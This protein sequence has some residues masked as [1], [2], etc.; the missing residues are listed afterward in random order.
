MKTIIPF[1]VFSICFYPSDT[2]A[3]ID[4]LS[5]EGEKWNR[6]LE[7]LL[8]V[9]IHTENDP[10]FLDWAEA[11]CDSLYQLVGYETFA[12]DQRARIDQ[13]RDICGDNLN[14]RAPLLEMFRG[15]PEYMGFA[16]DAVEYALEDA[17][18]KLITRPLIFNSL[19][20]IRNGSLDAIV[21]QGTVPDDLWEIA[22]DILDMETNHNFHRTMT[23][24]QNH[25]DSIIWSAQQNPNNSN[26]KD[27]ADLKEINRFAVIQINI[28]DCVDETLWIVEMNVRIWDE[29]EGFGPV[30][31]AKGF[32]EDKT[33]SPFFW[34]LLNFVLLSFL[35]LT[36]IS[37]IEHTHWGVLRENW[38]NTE[39]TKEK[40][41]F[42]ALFPLSYLKVAVRRMPKTL[43]FLIIPAVTSYIIIQACGPL[44]PGPTTHY[45]EIVAKFWIIGTA[46]GMSLIPTIL[47]FF[48]L[49]R[50]NLDGFHSMKS[51]R[52]LANVSLFG[53]FIPVMYLHEV[54]GTSM[55]ESFVYILILATWMAGDLLAF[56]LTEILSSSKSLRTKRVA[57]IGLLLGVGGV[58]KLTFLVIGSAHLF[59]SIVLTV[60]GGVVNLIWRP[61]MKWAQNKDSLVEQGTNL[62]ADLEEGD[63]VSSLVPN[64]EQIVR[65]IQGPKYT[66]GYIIGPTGIGKT[67]LIKELKKQLASKTEDWRVFIGDCDELQEE[68]HLAFEPFV[69]AFGKLLNIDEVSDRSEIIDAL[70]QS[71]LSAVADVG[72]IAINLKPVEENNQRSLVDFSM[73]LVDHLEKTKGN[74]LFILDDVQW[75][76]DD[77]KKLLLTFW[78][79]VV[80][81]VKLNGRLKFLCTYRAEEDRIS[82]R[83][84]QNDFYDLMRKLEAESILE[85]DGFICR[86]FLK[87]LSDTN[88]EFNVSTNS[89]Y[90]LNNV[91]NKKLESDSS[92][93]IKVVTPLYIIRNIGLLQSNGVLVTGSE[94]WV[95]SRE[96]TVEDLPNSEAVDAH[97]HQIFSKYPAKWMRVLESASIVGR[98]FDATVLSAVWGYELLEVLDFLEQLEAHDILEDVR[99]EDN[100]YRFK[101]K[102]A[103]AGI[104]S[105]FPNNSGDR[106]AR[107]IVIEYTKRLVNTNS[108][109]I[110]KR[111]LHSSGDLWKHLERLLK[112]P[113][114]YDQ[115]IDTY[116]LIEELAIRFAL[117]AEEFGVSPLVKLSSLLRQYFWAS[118]ANQVSTL[119]AVL[120]DDYKEALNRIKILPEWSSGDLRGLNSYT[121]L[122]FDREHVSNL[123]PGQYEMLNSE[124]RR[125]MGLSI[126]EYSQGSLWLGVISLLLSHP[127]VKADGREEIA[128]LWKKRVPLL[129]EQQK[130]SI[131]TFELEIQGKDGA[132]TPEELLD[133]WQN[134][135]TEVV[136]FG[137]LRNQKVVAKAI[138]R[139]FKV[140]TKNYRDAINWFITEES[141]FRVNKSDGITIIWYEVFQE[142]IA[143]AYSRNILCSE[144]TEQLQ[145]WS[146]EIESYFNLR[147]GQ[148]LFSPHVF[149]SIKFNIQ[150]NLKLE[151]KNSEE[152]QLEA[153]NILNYVKKFDNIHPKNIAIAL[154]L[155]ANVWQNDNPKKTFEILKEVNRIYLKLINEGGNFKRAMAVSCKSLTMHCR[156]RLGDFDESLKWANEGLKWG[157][158]IYGEDKNFKISS[159]Y[160]F[161]GAAL[162]ELRK[163]EEASVA[164][165]LAL[166]DLEPNSEASR[167]HIALYS[168]HKGASQVRAKIDGGNEVLKTAIE[169]LE[170]IELSPFVTK[171]NSKKIQ[172]LKSLLSD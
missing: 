158:D 110:S 64:L 97:F 20:E 57:V 26:L 161:K 52:D 146:E 31:S 94:G 10:K 170:T 152:I 49:N 23:L 46:V 106:N 25:L 62:D 9:S 126:H 3:S 115:N 125:D 99:D 68:G 15:R 150:I 86:D 2:R 105:F 83:I 33:S 149:N 69:E 111:A 134:H 45:Q 81:N 140:K 28:Q 5:T 43:L 127:K 72:P 84:N 30:I 124:T 70:G 169:A 60:A 35:L 8:F 82:K 135:W 73:Q 19:T 42:I 108:D 147:Y 56:C 143:N 1:L 163:F 91:L 145:K 136:N 12:Q 104:K 144:H 129:S 74:I 77:S 80:R 90:E 98:S 53:S 71:A 58:V 13:T 116:Y 107:Q 117:D 7:S 44:V 79:M 29:S 101:D 137:S 88:H 166:K 47:N 27:L 113:T 92:S 93:E 75:M 133:S 118:E 95:L 24:P 153:E 37:G 122:L 38:A 120:G 41:L 123:A 34:N 40:L 151:A 157:L 100:I 159:Y 172:E 76:D 154:N 162:G 55:E 139:V 11:Y 155:I 17:L 142:L 119:I 59:T 39:S 54:N 51:Y 165:D 66:S 61:L 4:S 78:G 171:S 132:V 128:A 96:I 50:L 102:R 160:F 130:I 131:S 138:L 65:H 114:T 103:V 167:F 89:L 21:Q 148:E 112:V 87:G 121:R 63:Y 85:T 48:I 168:M 32:C 6:H 109:L 164:F 18:R 67:R 22:L 141:K 36:L 16:D 156:N 14:H